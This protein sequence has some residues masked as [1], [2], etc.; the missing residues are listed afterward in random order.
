MNTSASDPKEYRCRLNIIYYDGTSAK[1]YYISAY[2]Q[3]ISTTY[4]KRTS[5]GDLSVSVVDRTTLTAE[6]KLWSANTGHTNAPR[7]TVT[8]TVNGI[9]ASNKTY[10]Y[11]KTVELIADGSQRIDGVDKNITSASI[12]LEGLEEGV[13]MVSYT[14]SGNRYFKSFT[15]TDSEIGMWAKRARLSARYCAQ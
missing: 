11:S 5:T 4:S 2:S 7:G 1:E 13:Y 14:Y 9:L 10:Y 12:S 6:A 15:L 3:P 8:F